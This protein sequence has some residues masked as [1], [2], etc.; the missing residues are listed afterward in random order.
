[1]SLVAVEFVRKLAATRV[2]FGGDWF[3]VHRSEAP[4]CRDPGIL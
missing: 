3:A 1:L 4:V 2:T